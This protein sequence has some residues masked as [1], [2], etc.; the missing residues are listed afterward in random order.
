MSATPASPRTGP[1]TV[2]RSRVVG[3]VLAILLVTLA[4]VAYRLSD[5]G[6][7]E[8][9]ASS[10][11]VRAPLDVATGYQSGRVVVSDVRVAS[12]LTEGDDTFRTEGLFVVVHLAVQAPGR[13][14]VTVSGSRLLSREGTTY[15]PAFSLGTIT[16]AE[17]GFETSRDLVFEVDPARIDGLT[18][19]LWDQGL[20]Y[21]YFDR[22]Q[23]PLGITAANAAQWREAGTGRTVEVL[24]DDLVQALA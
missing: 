3:V 9:Y 15:R 14:E 12:E 4:A 1:R 21:R 20:T 2:G 6:A 11:L 5:P 8:Q 13:D 19:E 18:L 23:T 17:P 10:D 24:R 7:S 16:K 22:T